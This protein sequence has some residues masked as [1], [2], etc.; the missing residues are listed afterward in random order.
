MEFQPQR[1]QSITQGTQS[2][3]FFVFLKTKNNFSLRSLR[4]DEFRLFV[5]E[6]KILFFRTL[7]FI[8]NNSK[9]QFQDL[10]TLPNGLMKIVNC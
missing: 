6:T 1:P 7:A 4:L 8:K 2:F 3:A 10:L 9:W 5:Y